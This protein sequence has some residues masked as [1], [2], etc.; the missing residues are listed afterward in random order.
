[1]AAPAPT[2]AVLLPVADKR[3]RH[4]GCTGGL[5]STAPPDMFPAS[6]K[7][8]L[9][10]WRSIS[11]IAVVVALLTSGPVMGMVALAAALRS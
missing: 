4:G 10:V 1:M 2:Q 11:G 3:G 9:H 6:L 8:S 7:R 5:L